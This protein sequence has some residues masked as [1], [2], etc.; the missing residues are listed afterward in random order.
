MTDTSAETMHESEARLSALEESEAK[1]RILFETMDEGVA[2]CELV[3]DADQRVV[4]Y[5]YLE[6]NRAFESHIGLN[7]ADAEGRLRSEVL[8]A[9]DASWLEIYERVVTE[10]VSV[11]TEHFSPALGRWFDV[12]AF[13]RGGDRF[14]VLFENITAR[15]DAEVALRESEARYR[16]L[17]T[18]SADVVYRMSADWGEMRRLDGRGLLLDTDEPSGA[19]L[20]RYLHPDDHARVTA[21]I[22]KAVRGRGPFALEHR[23]IRAD[24]TL[25]WTQSRAVPVFDSAG[26]IVEWIGTASDITTRK[27]AELA[28]RAS[29]ARYRVLFDSIDEGFC[30]IEVL[31]DAAERAV[32][33]R[34][35]EAN[36]AFAQQTGLTDV[37]G[38]TMRELAPAHEAYW[39]ETYGQIALTGESKRFEAPA[40][41]LGGRWYD[42]YAFRAGQRGEHRVAILFNDV[43]A[44]KRAETILKASE[45]RRAFLLKL[46][47]AIGPLVDPSAIQ[48]AACRLLCEHLD[49]QRVNYADVEADEFIIR[50][51][52]TRGAAPIIGRGPVASYAHALLEEYRTAGI[53]GI[54]DVATDPRL[55]ERERASYARAEIAA[56]ASVMLMKADRW[57]ASFAAHSAT[58]RQW[59]PLELALVRETAERVWE[60][61]ERAKAEAALRASEA[62]QV[63]LLALSDALR[64]LTDPVAIQGEAAR[65]IGEHLGA[66]RVLYADTEG[67][68][69]V[70]HRDWVRGI[71]S[72]AGRYP[73][74]EWGEYIAVYLRGEPY[75]V[76][77]VASDPKVDETAIASYR[78][79]D[80]AAF[81]GLGLVKG[82]A[83]VASFGVHSRTPRVWTTE[84]IE[85]ARETAERTWAAVERA[86]VQAALHERETQLR[87]AIDAT[88]LGVYDWDIATDRIHVN[89]QYREMYDLP[90]DEAIF[91]S[92]MLSGQ[93]HP[94]DRPRIEARVAEAF[95]PRSSGYYEVEH[96]AIVRG[97]VRWFRGIGQ[98]YF[99]GDGEARHPARLV[100]YI[101]DIT[102]RKLSDEA[103]EQTRSHGERVALTR[104]L[105][106]AEEAER[107]R[108]AREVHDQLGQQLTAVSLILAETRL[109]IEAGEP[110]G[111]RLLQ[112]EALA[113]R[114]TRDARYFALELRPPELDDV[115]LES[116]LQTYI[117]QWS[118]RYGVAAD[119]AVT[120]AA[121]DRLLPS[122]VRTAIYRIAQEALTNVARHAKAS[123]AS[124][125]LEKLD[126]EARLI[127]EDNGCGFEPGAT[128]ARAKAEQ[129]LGHAGM[130]ERATLVGG[131][132]DV[133]SSPGSGTAV[134]VR[135]PLPVD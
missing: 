3:R 80:V 48:A 11:H 74:S 5:R 70:V 42:V 28:L 60:A 41:A 53:I 108:L 111:E 107:R 73:A 1:Y 25:G 64:P 129:R 46:S 106:M 18:A 93:V 126:D 55:G 24:G 12:R 37:V 132:V 88:G 117:E 119:L 92:K 27:E 89:A 86:R 110:V 43:A 130:R 14:G 56:T 79:V 77:D 4:D 69:I 29:E 78:S 68:T 58:P 98:V 16:A 8:P 120:G 91:V 31:F 49:V 10:G 123:H 114:L 125:L 124:V 100:G 95:D 9:S 17:V 35:L 97:G 116:A 15:K 36:P 23:V 75:L 122:D 82:G 66:D 103:S 94:D 105:A 115:G 54:S 72:M 121:A 21:A 52:H 102:D 84:E 67:D 33:Y 128:A 96:R 26:E 112:L 59:T 131:T 45:E 7:R 62:R 109:R 50:S 32:D 87:L 47:D 134:Y 65:L 6:L 2:L 85:L 135:V 71:A 83:H 104:Q 113:G 51:S 118:A 13:P 22:D 39:F 40:Q 19:W 81:I 20:A 34:F 57:V 63:Y 133:E 76:H 90:R 101:Q 38:R 30:V 44:R 99:A 127:V 61:V